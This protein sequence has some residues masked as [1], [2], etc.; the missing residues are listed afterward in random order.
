MLNIEEVMKITGWC[1]PVTR[2]LFAYDKD[3]PAIKIGKSYQVELDAFK[4]YLKQR[5]SGKEVRN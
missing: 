1:E 2:K 3:F 4:E 5:R